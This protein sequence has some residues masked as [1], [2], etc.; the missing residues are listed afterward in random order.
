MPTGVP[1]NGSETV[2]E[3]RRNRQRPDQADMQM[4]NVPTGGSHSQEGHLR[5]AL[6]WTVGRVYTRVSMRGSLS[7]SRPHETLGHQFDGGVFLGLVKAVEGVKILAS[8][9]CGYE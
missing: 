6:P 8:E 1:V 4:T 7:H 3:A 2:P 5:A 9:G